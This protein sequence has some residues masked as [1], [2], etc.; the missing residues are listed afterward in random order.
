[1]QVSFGKIICRKEAGIVTPAQKWITKDIA[2]AFEYDKEK[3]FAYGADEVTGH[4]LTL[5]EFIKRKKDAD[6]VITAKRNNTV[7]VALEKTLCDRN[8]EKVCSYVI[9]GN[10]YEPYQMTFNIKKVKNPILDLQN[11]TKKFVKRCIYF[12]NH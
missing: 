4:E 8:G 1:M 7:S 5:H 11:M 6:V 9:K 12:A 3:P 10:S 2:N